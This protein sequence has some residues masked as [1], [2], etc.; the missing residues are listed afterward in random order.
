MFEPFARS[1][2]RRRGWGY[3]RGLLLD[4]ARK[5]VELMAARPGRGRD[6]EV[7]AHFVTSSPWDVAHVRARRAWRM[8][9][10]IKPTHAGHR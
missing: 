5:S 3:L 4:G 8:Q 2:Q 9:P 7:L 6:R 1:D 10:V